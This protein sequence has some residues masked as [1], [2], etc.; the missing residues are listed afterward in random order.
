MENVR[1]LTK[2]T[3]YSIMNILGPKSGSLYY[4]E[5][6][7]LQIEMGDM[8][9]SSMMY[10]CVCGCV[11]YTICSTALFCTIHPILDRSVMK[12]SECRPEFCPDLI[13]RTEV[14]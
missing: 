10:T 6:V 2:D 1:R 13:Y 5:P 12:P 14:K 11:Y 9:R 4:I 7:C 3:I 8:H